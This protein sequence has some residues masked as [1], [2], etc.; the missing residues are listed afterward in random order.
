MLY[1]S[2]PCVQ[3]GND[4]D[5][6][7]ESEPNS[8][9]DNSSDSDAEITGQDI[10]VFEHAADARPADVPAARSPSPGSRPIF[11]PD[12]PQ[13][14]PEEGRQHFEEGHLRL[15]IGNQ[16]PLLVINTLHYLCGSFHIYIYKQCKPSMGRSIWLFK[17]P[18]QGQQHAV[19]DA[20]VADQSSKLQEVQARLAQLNPQIFNAKWKVTFGSDSSEYIKLIVMLSWDQGPFLNSYVPIYIPIYTHVSPGSERGK[21]PSTK[22]SRRWRLSL[23]IR[24]QVWGT[25]RKSNNP[26]RTKPKCSNAF[27]YI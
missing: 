3:D 9:D 17:R 7:S 19:C 21:L 6:Y 10:E 22:L 26:E 16:Q 2:H 18:R 12:A 25:C 11:P 1:R 13:I 8:S 23:L 27:F 14:C 4:P 20:V 5:A 15:G 24:Q